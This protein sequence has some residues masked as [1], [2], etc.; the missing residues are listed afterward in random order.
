VGEN[1]FISLLSKAQ[2]LQRVAQEIQEQADSLEAEVRLKI[3][4][5]LSEQNELR[6][7]VD[8]FSANADSLADA[9]F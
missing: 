6:C 2:K 7:R 8:P 4:T 1:D 9:D 5:L 3:G